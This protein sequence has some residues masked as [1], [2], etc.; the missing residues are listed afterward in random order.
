ME[1]MQQ[2]LAKKK[3]LSPAQYQAALWVG[4]RQVTG[5]ESPPVSFMELLEQ[6]IQLTAKKRG[7]PETEVLRKF[8]S[9]EQPLLAIAGPP[10]GGLLDEDEKKKPLTEAQVR[11]M[12]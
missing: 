8:I 3:G 2:R 9:G 12:L 11:D 6:R 1:K 4:A 5:M 7:L 10:V